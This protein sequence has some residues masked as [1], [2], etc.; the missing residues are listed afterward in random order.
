[1]VG[2]LLEEFEHQIERLTLTPSRGGVFEVSV[3]G[4][5]VFSKKAAGRHADYDEV[6]GPL[7]KRLGDPTPE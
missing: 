3:D 2:A 6:A 1:M 7:R 4:D 5:L